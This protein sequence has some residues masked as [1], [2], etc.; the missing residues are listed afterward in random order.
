MARSA[1]TPGA[2]ITHAPHPARTSTTPPDKDL[3][4]SRSFRDDQH[5]RV[6]AERA[7]LDAELVKPRNLHRPRRPRSYPRV[8]K[9]PRRSSFPVKRPHHY[10]SSYR[11]TTVRLHPMP[12]P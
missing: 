4:R 9:K 10:G 3:D 12:Q 7:R 5:E 6:Q 8:V 11:P 1:R 2:S